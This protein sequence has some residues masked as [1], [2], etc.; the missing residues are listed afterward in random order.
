[1]VLSYTIVLYNTYSETDGKIFNSDECVRVVK[2]AYACLD[3]TK[4]VQRV[5]RRLVKLYRVNAP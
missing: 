4:H 2:Y 5:T 1:M 3:P